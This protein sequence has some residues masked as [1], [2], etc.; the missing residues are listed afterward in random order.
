MTMTMT[1]FLMAAAI[2]SSYVLASTLAPV[3]FDF[4]SLGEK[5]AGDLYLPSGP[6]PFPIT[7]TGPGFAGVKEMLIPDYA[8]ALA[9]AG[10]A[11]LAFDYIG[12]GSSTGKVR[13]DIKPPE[14]IQTYRDSID[15][16]AK[17]S[18]FDKNR[19]GAWG[20]SLGGAHTLV[21]SSTDP[22]VKAGVA[23]IPHI[24]IDPATMADRLSI[25]DAIEADTK[26]SQT[27]GAP[28]VMIGV[29]GEP[30]ARAALTSDGAVAW[31]KDVTKNA[32][33][34]KNE[35]TAMS[36]LGMASYSTL[37][38]AK[39]IKIPLLAITA[40]SDSITPAKKIHEA[41]DGVKSVQFKD[42][43][44][45]HFGLFGANLTAT[46]DLTVDWFQKHLK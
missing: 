19:I 41:M 46:I 34:Y 33:T 17:D 13:Q 23:I 35:V 5:S 1:T 10:I 29:S 7:I 4:P 32:P 20:T 43:P 28:R 38:D 16:V 30:G 15:A 27:P 14:Q 3:K 36:M 21:V 11:T 37:E 12:F 22:R 42:F 6:G 39:K 25:I 26:A 31:T 45:T 40:E 9:K 44:G 2:Q 24:E 8:N 18:R